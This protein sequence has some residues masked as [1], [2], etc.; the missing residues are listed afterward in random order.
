MAP[1]LAQA[2][3]MGRK[4]SMRQEHAIGPGLHAHEHALRHRPQWGKGGS[5]EFQSREPRRTAPG[6]PPTPHSTRALSVCAAPKT[7]P[8]QAL[9]RGD[10]PYDAGATRRIVA[11]SCC[12]S[13]AAVLSIDLVAHAAHRLNQGTCEALVDLLTQVVNVDIHDIGERLQV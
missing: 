12:F 3:Q 5:I 8:L 4:L 2:G 10:P 9:V 6:P 11:C 7:G 1:G 13:F